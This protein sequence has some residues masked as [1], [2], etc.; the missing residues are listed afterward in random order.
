MPIVVSMHVPSAVATRSV[1]LND[2]DGARHAPDARPDVP[3][4]RLEAREVVL[5]LEQD[6][7]F[8]NPRVIQLAAE[9]PGIPLRKRARQGSMDDSILVR[10][11][12]RVEPGV[13]RVSRLLQVE[14]AN[15]RRQPRIERALEIG[16]RQRRM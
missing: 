11:R 12:A 8:A 7:R 10:F 14:D 1:G 4:R 16:R 3:P 6:R 9:V 13:E 15:I 2:P 5:A